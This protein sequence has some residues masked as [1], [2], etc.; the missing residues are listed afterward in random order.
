MEG[1]SP[2]FTVM[3]REGEEFRGERVRRE[4]CAEVEPWAG[5]GWGAL[6]G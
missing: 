1:V 2:S 3:R 5:R 4:D 6:T